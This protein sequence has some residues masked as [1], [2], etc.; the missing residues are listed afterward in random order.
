MSKGECKTWT[1]DQGTGPWTFS[2]QEDSTAHACLTTCLSAGW[3]LLPGFAAKPHFP[4]AKHNQNL[5]RQRSHAFMSHRIFCIGHLLPGFAAR[6]HFPQ[7]KHNSN[8][9]RQRTYA[10]TSHRT[11]CVRH[12]LLGF[13]A[14]PHF[15]QVK[16]NSNLKRQRSHASSHTG[17]FVLVICSLDLQPDLTSP[18]QNTTVT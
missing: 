14:R 6:P 15:P 18:K 13:A 1:G 2:T 7:L 4:Q 10:F 9:K 12:L 3:H 11:F 8:L 5:K 17:L 16:H